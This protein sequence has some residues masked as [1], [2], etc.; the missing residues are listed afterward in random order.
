VLTLKTPA[1]PTR[2]FG[3]Y[4][5]KPQLSGARELSPAH[6]NGKTVDV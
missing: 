2:F 6:E 3:I 5:L 4:F 1:C